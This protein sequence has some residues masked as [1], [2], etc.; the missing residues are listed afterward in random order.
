MLRW[1]GGGL[2]WPSVRQ[3]EYAFMYVVLCGV[4]GRTVEARRY[5]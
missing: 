1:T 5:D 3:E 4:L 2:C